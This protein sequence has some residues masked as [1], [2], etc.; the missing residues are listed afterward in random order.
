MLNEKTQTQKNKCCI[1]SFICGFLC[2]ISY[3]NEKL[4]KAAEE[5]KSKENIWG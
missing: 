1:L 5:G 2:P 4:G 3:V